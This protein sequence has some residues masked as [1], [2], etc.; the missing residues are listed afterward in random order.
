MEIE[1]VRSARRHKTVQARVDDGTLRVMIPARFTKAE[2]AHWVSVMQERVSQ[3]RRRTRSEPDLAARAMALAQ[4]HDLPEPVSIT[5][6]TRQKQRWGSCTPAH[7]SIRISSLCREFPDWVTDYV[8][9]H[10][11]AHL[12]ESNHN[13]TFHALVERYPLAERAKGYLLAK[14]DSTDPDWD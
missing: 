8:I 5:W 4:A 6:S 13:R 7:G 14:S 10:E 3:A 2:E 12:V 1:V 9:V 11:L